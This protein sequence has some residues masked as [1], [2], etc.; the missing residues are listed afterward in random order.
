MG[1][2]ATEM[3]NSVFSQ[4]SDAKEIPEELSKLWASYKGF[5]DYSEGKWQQIIKQR[6]K[7][8]LKRLKQLYWS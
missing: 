8:F 2:L 3:F 7:E 4:I 1:T 5:Y 6:D